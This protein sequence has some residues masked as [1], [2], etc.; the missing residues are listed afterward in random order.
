MAG[1]ELAGDKRAAADLRAWLVFEDESGQGLR[2]PTGRT[3][4]YRGRTPMVRVTA[5]KIASRGVV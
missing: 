3:W 1:G 4:G 5:A 2:P